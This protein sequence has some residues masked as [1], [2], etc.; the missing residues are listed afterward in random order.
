MIVDH[1]TPPPSKRQEEDRDREARIVPF[2]PKPQRP[3]ASRRPAPDGDDPL[4]PAA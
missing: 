4:P 1:G 2:R 3:T